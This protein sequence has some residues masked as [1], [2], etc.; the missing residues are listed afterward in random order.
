MANITTA[1]VPTIPS[2]ASFRSSELWP[3][4]GSPIV[5]LQ[6]GTSI[7]DGSQA[8]YSVSLTDKS[9][10]DNGTTCLVDLGG[11]RWFQVTSPE[12]SSGLITVPEGGTGVA[13]L[14]SG[15]FVT[16]ADAAPVTLTIPGAGVTTFITT[17]TS[18][19]LAAAVTNETGTGSLVFATSPTLVTP[20]LG[21][22]TSGN[23]ANCVGYP[24]SAL[25]GLGAGV[26]TWLTT[27]SSSNLAAAVTDETGT[28]SLV[29]ATS[30][31][32]V[33]PIL[34]TPTSGNLANCTGF[35][36]ASLTGLGAGVATFLATPSSANLATAV[37]DETGSGQL[38]FATSP[39]LVTPLLGTPTSGNLANT[40][41]YPTATAAQAK[42][43]TNA[44]AVL[45]PKSLLDVG[46]FRLLWIL[47]N[48]NMNS[49][50]DQAF[51]KVGTFTNF[52]LTQLRAYYIS[53]ASETLAVGGIY[54]AASKGGDALVANSQTYTG[55]TG[56]ATGQTLAQTALGAGKRS[57]ASI[58]LSLT[59]AQGTAAVADI[60]MFGIAL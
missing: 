1:K 34:D 45:S 29:F 5:Y 55:L 36:T 26:A 14:A 59:T 21:T 11:Y 35:P 51:T 46:A 2:I 57:D 7:L 53:G 49:T 32:F 48:A 18:A 60:Y 52:A 16:G 42:D 44:T 13:T 19:N 54:S 24:T 10:A 9:T 37:T 17:P 20:L 33:T 28:G 58:F 38:V 22:P 50:A 41:G 4:S 6:G 31:T 30:P 56:A 47:A 40:T 15:G 8:F 23:L 12:T 3:G 39:T 25:T 43:T 27:P